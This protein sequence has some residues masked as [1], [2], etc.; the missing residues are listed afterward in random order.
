MVIFLSLKMKNEILKIILPKR[1]VADVESD[2]EK[3][4]GAIPELKAEDGFDQ[5][6]TYHD[7]DVFEHTL[8]VLESLDKRTPELC[9]AALLHDI[10]KPECFS[11][12][13]NGYGHF[14]GH[15]DAGAEKAKAIMERLGFS[16][17]E[18]DEAVRLIALHD[19]VPETKKGMRKTIVANGIDFV[20]ELIELAKA[21]G[22][23]HAP[24]ARLRKETEMAKAEFLVSEIEAD[25]AKASK[26]K[27]AING[28]DLIAIGYEPGPAIGAELER[29]LNDVV[30]EKVE[31]SRESLLSE[32]KTD[33]QIPWED[34]AEK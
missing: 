16:L 6:S 1:N 17:E 4:F 5:K 13:A 12:D 27:L 34:P 24:E 33:A 18:T 19:S 14:Y 9:M 21:D 11:V 26:K 25:E 10:A 31:N 8:T 23:G 29:L 3:L 30:G 7:K 32:A 2:K 28:N 22:E 20:K 15:E